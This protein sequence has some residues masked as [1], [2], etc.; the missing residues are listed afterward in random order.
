MEDDSG[1]FEAL[2]SH[3]YF[4]NEQISSGKF[5]ECAS[6]ITDVSSI[7]YSITKLPQAKNLNM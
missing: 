1:T 4:T 7:A 6:G 2:A 3:T 5:G